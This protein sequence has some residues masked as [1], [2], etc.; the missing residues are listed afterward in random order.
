MLLD[1]LLVAANVVVPLIVLIAIGFLANMRRWI[2]GD[3]FRQLNKLVF[4]VLLP[5]VIF[6]NVYSAS[7]KELV[8][9]NMLLYGLGAVFVV[10]ICGI[11]VSGLM[12]RDPY[13]RGVAL[14]AI[15]RSN[16]V[17][18]GFPIVQSMY[19]RD[20]LGPVSVLIAVIIPVFNI[21][22]IIALEMFRSGQVDMRKIIIGIIKNPL[23]IGAVAG[24]LCSFIGL[25]LP[26]VLSRSLS[27]LSVA[28]TPVALI[29]LGGTFQLQTLGENKNLL[30]SMASFKLLIV[31]AIFLSAA[32]FFGFRDVEL[33]AF[34][35]LFGS[36]AAVS[37]FSMAQLMGADSELAGQNLLTTTVLSVFTIFMWVW[38]LNHFA[39][40]V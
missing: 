22:A 12:T 32:I 20:R 27:N 11:P 34:V 29:I 17:L 24:I 39:F 30:I 9:T 8:N 21:L 3:S 38:L 4:N 36:P 25:E 18:Y 31:P 23:I 7:I 1:S 26:Q 6:D 35:S 2:S 33:L 13:K 28:A 37:T 10:F 15:F 14:Q 19:P 5:C 40:I 16:F